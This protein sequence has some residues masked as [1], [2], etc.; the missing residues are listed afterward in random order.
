MVTIQI[1][2]TGFVPTSTI[3]V[4]GVWS[5]L[6]SVSKLDSRLHE[7]D[8]RRIRGIGNVNWPQ[9]LAVVSRVSALDATSNLLIE[10]YQSAEDSKLKVLIDVFLDVLQTEIIDPTRVLQSVLGFAMPRKDVQVVDNIGEDDENERFQTQSILLP[11]VRS[12]T[13][14]SSDAVTILDELDL[15]GSFLFLIR[16]FAVTGNRFRFGNAR[17]GMMSGSSGFSPS[18]GTQ[19]PFSPAGFASLGNSRQL[20][21]D[22]HYLPLLKARGK[23]LV[24]NGSKASMI[25]VLRCLGDPD[26]SED[27]IFDGNM[28]VTI[29]SANVP[30]ADLANNL[31]ILPRPLGVQIVLQEDTS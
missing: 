3:S 8:R 9:P 22:V 16:P 19:Y 18:V 5:T 15:V 1:E 4:G 29:Q 10:Q 17:L 20:D 2:G 30:L 24:A 14:D 25:G 11:I 7:T 23:S 27:D 13:Q 12:A 26:I 31:S 28:T 21:S 6:T